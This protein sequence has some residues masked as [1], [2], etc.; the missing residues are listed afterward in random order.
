MPPP[1][2]EVQIS[3][4]EEL[5]ERLIAV[6]S[7]LGFEGFWED[8]TLLKCYMSSRRW[9]PA[10]A[11]EVRTTVTRMQ[12]SSSTPRPVITVRL[13]EDRN[14]NEEWEKTITPIHVTDHII[15]KPTWQDYS[16][17]PDELLITI[18]PKMSF[19]T[20]YHET[21]R[22]ALRLMEKHI[23]TGSRLLDIGT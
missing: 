15:I 16:P 23:K 2:I 18:D 12:H 9:N 17:A 11:D 19:G 6:L 22:L 10:L 14:W 3:S 5:V 7:Q 1:Y 20:G 13:I 4:S 21:T 8:S